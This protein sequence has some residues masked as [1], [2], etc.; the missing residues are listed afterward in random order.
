MIT[1]RLFSE[2]QN[3]VHGFSDRTD[4]NMSV[5]ASEIQHQQSEDFRA[6]THTNRQRFL[7]GLGISGQDAVLSRQTHATN[8]ALV[9]PDHKGPSDTNPSPFESADGLLTNSLNTY[10]TIFSA[11]CMPVFIIDPEQQRVAAVHAGWRGLAGGIIVKALGQLKQQ[12]T[13]L[14]QARVWIGPHIQSC[15]YQVLTN[16]PHYSEKVAA[17][18][19]MPEAIVERNGDSF[20]DLTGVAMRQLVDQGISPQYIEV[21]ECTACHPDK[22]FSYHASQGRPD[23]IMMGVVGW[24]IA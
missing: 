6:T 8:I 3:L 19:S 17:F 21:G 7:E 14:T 11:D 2:I 15:H 10:L 9:T 24:Q 4:G 20:L 18:A 23:G 1:S 22:Y 13:D 5:K 12:G 16:V